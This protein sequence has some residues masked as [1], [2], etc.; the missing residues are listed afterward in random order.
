MKIKC[1]VHKAQF[2]NPSCE[3]KFVLIRT[4]RDLILELFLGHDCHTKHAPKNSGEEFLGAGYIELHPPYVYPEW[5]SNSFKGAQKYGYDRP[6]DEE[7]ADCLLAKIK[8]RVEA[9]I[10]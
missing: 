2:L 6:K 4:G 9:W 10:R 3:K 8:E 5:G 1:E 7:E